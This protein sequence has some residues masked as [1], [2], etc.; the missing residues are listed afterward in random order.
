MSV[1]FITGSSR[2][3]GL[4]IARAAL[5]NGHQVVATARDKA[6]VTRALGSSERLLAVSLD[7]TEAGRAATAVEEA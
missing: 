1:W 2:G 4:E 7:V 5:E 3:L 6:A